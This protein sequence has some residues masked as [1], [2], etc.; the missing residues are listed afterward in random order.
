[1]QLGGSEGED[2][3]DDEFD[4]DIDLDPDHDA[5]VIDL[6]SGDS[7]FDEDDDE[8]SEADADDEE[9]G[10]S[11]EGGAPFFPP[12]PAE[13]LEEGWDDAE[14]WD[15]EVRPPQQAPVSAP[16]GPIQQTQEM[17]EYCSAPGPSLLRA[18]PLGCCFECWRTHPHRQ[19]N[20]V[21]SALCRMKRWTTLREPGLWAWTAAGF[22]G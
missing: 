15:G 11:N 5:N 3:T 13:W 6:S 14:G 20:C 9:D 7:D 8:G 1:M 22:T 12:H 10:D 19:S 21:A 4:S 17:R 18:P 2:W 16:V